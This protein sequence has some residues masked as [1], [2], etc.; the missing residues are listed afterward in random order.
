MNARILLLALIFGL[1]L[2][3]NLLWAQEVTPPEKGPAQVFAELDKNGDGILTAAEVGKDHKRFFERLL[4]VGDKNKDGELTRQEFLEGFKPDELKV[5]APQNLRGGGGYGQGDLNEMFQRFDRNKDGKLTIDEVPEQAR[6]RVKPIFD[7]LKKKELTR[8]EFVQAVGNLRGAGGN[9]M[10]DPEGFF[11]KL[12]S[13][14][15]GKLTVDEVPE[16]SRP[17]VERWL[18]RLG[19]KKSDSVTLD[20][21]KKI[22]AENQAR[23]SGPGELQAPLFRKLDTN[24]DGKLSKEELQRAAEFFNEFDVNKDGFLEPR[25]LFTPP[26]DGAESGSKK[27]SLEKIAGPAISDADRSPADPARPSKD[28]RGRAPSGDGQGAMRLL[29]TD[30]DGRIARS[31]ARGRLKE[32]FDTLDSNGDGYLEVAE[33]RVALQRLGMK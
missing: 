30:G 33:L 18:N 1:V 13:N 17:L 14:A 31:E 10:R 25:E 9:F 21:L 26:G 23:G 22:V 32:K 16:S 4:R 3:P 15:D 8:D 12:D 5:L 19:K 24:G 2:A 11:K 28:R 27:A 7:Q 29:D 6:G 20:D